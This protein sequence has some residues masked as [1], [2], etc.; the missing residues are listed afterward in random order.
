MKTNLKCPCG[1]F[2]TGTDEDDLVARAQA[3]LTEEHPGLAYEREQ[4]LFMAY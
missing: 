4:I 1:A 2:L 3:H